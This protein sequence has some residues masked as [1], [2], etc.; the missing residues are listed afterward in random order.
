[1]SYPQDDSASFDAP[2]G[3]ESLDTETLLAHDD[4]LAAIAEWGPREAYRQLIAQNDRLILAPMLDTG[5]EI[6]ARR[7][8]IHSGL[9][10]H[11]LIEQRRVHGYDRPFA[12]VATGG[13]GRG[14][15]TP[16]SDT[17]FALL[18]ED[19]KD[20]HPF[21][22]SLLQ[23]TIHTKQFESGYGFSIWPQPFN[24]DHAPTLRGMQLNAFLDMRAVY[25]PHDLTRRFR[26]RV[27]ATFDPFE[28]FL[29]VSQMWRAT[30]RCRSA[31]NTP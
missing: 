31:P 28:H 15:V 6:T 11:W 2:S 13:T 4:A 16:C 27:R 1:M 22:K 20:G 30:P 26:E 5:R 25:D 12:L 10:T 9:A 14:E 17:D 29:H 8:A 18:F 3:S 21:L 23:Q 19:E 7:T 24:L